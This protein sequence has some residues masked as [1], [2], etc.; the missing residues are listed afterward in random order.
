VV[1][2]ADAAGV[3]MVLVADTAV[4]LYSPNAIRASLGTVFTLPV[5]SA[6]GKE[7]LRWLRAQ[8]T[9]IFA[10]RVD[11]AVEYTSVCYQG[12]SAIVLGSEAQGLSPLWK[13][14]D[15]TAVSLPMLGRADSLNVS[16]T[17][18]VLIYEALRQKRNS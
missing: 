18:G 7:V 10:A 14:P 9:A 8:Q 2:T 13:G 1:R 3:Q 16:V 6:T 12:R 4:D 17:A 5:V 15:V 11:G